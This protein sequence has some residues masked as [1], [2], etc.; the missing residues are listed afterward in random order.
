MKINLLITSL[1]LL[2]FSIG[3]YAQE[4]YVVID[5]DGTATFYYNSS[6]PEGALPIQS[7][8]KDVNWPEN[9]RNSVSKVVFDAS[10]NDYKPT[11]GAYWFWTFSNL[12]EISGMKEYLHT[13]N[14]TDMSY[15][16]YGCKFKSL[17]LSS[18][19]TERVRNMSCM[20]KHS[21]QLETIVLTSFNT[22]NVTDMA[23]MFESCSSLTNIDLS[24]FNTSFVTTM[25]CMFLS[26]IS[27]T[28]LDLGS[29]NTKKVNNLDY[30]FQY[31]SQLKTIYVSDGWKSNN[32]GTQMFYD[33][34]KIL[35]GGNTAFNADHTDATYAK[36]DGGSENPGYF[37][38]SSISALISDEPYVIVKDGVAIFYSALS[39][40]EGAL[41]MRT[42]QNDKN[43]PNSLYTTI[44]NVVFDESFKKCKPFSTSFWF[45]GFENLTDI[46]GMENI[47][48][49]NLEYM[50]E[51][52]QFCDNLP[53][54]DLSGFNTSRVTDMTRLFWGCNNLES[55]FVGE[56]WSTAALKKSSGMFEDCFKL[57]GGK[58]T[59][60][61]ADYTDAS[62][63]HI[64]GGTDNPGYFTGE[65]SSPDNPPTPVSSVDSTPGVKVWSFNRTIFIESAPD[66]KYTIIDLNG[67]ILKSSTTKSTKEEITVNQHGIVVVII[68]GDSYKVAVD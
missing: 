19:N 10:F 39:I 15:M 44:T 68:N 37:T 23:G 22:E 63:A 49:Y 36:I 40:P 32:G 46:A 12:D 31:C 3:V 47:N 33:C 5:Q 4:P 67:R 18:F 30:M 42:D 6:K 53:S 16:F 56:G 26:C 7:S 52:F 13:D 60:Y 25:R 61:N 17:D 59:A 66:T 29:F 9:V 38:K 43:W 55:V 50:N 64:D 51:M 24:S 2:L 14:I 48:T 54:V 34:K 8:S 41:P 11:S 35:G 27:L 57:Y 1:F 28:S 62:Y 20:F 58:G 21:K 65:Q 45:W